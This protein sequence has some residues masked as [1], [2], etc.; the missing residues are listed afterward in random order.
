MWFIGDTLS[1]ICSDYP[2]GGGYGVSPPVPLD[3]YTLT[4]GGLNVSTFFA[5]FSDFFSADG[6]VLLTVITG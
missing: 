2:G 5:I 4:Q 3:N 6:R 1:G